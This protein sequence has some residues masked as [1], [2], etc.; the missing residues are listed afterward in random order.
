[1]KG[2]RSINCF[3]PI[4]KV[5][6]GS[7]GIVHKAMD[8]ETGEILAIKRIKLERSKEGFPLSSFWEI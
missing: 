2:C 7:Y 1:M 5:D 8:W 3:K 6:E 4:S